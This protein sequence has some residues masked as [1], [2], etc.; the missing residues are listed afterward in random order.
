MTTNR[1]P[2]T[3]TVINL[4][5]DIGD[6]VI[7]D[8]CSKDYTFSDE[9]GG[10]VFGSNGVC[11]KCA[12]PMMEDIKAHNEEQ[13]IRAVCPEGMSHRQFIL[14]YRKGIIHQTY[15]GTKQ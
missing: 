13:Y 8:L 14:D 11:P 2:T 12:P 3:V 5:Q 4:T 10:F 1:K 7:C 6:M 9:P 15:R